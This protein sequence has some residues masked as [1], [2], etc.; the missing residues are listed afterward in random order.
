M[1]NRQLNA[2]IL[3]G[4][5]FWILIALSCNH[6]LRYGLDLNSWLSRRPSGS[7][8]AMLFMAALGWVLLSEFMALDCFR[9]G[10]QLPEMASKTST[11]ILLEMTFVLSGAFTLRLYYSRLVL[12]YFALTFWGGVVVVRLIALAILRKKHRAGNTRKVVLVGNGGVARALARRIQRHPELLYEVVGFLY[13]F[14]TTQVNTAQ[15]SKASPRSLSSLEVLKLITELRVNDLFILDSQPH[16]LEL[17]NF[18]VRCQERGIHVNF[19][20]QP[21]ELYASRP[22][23]IE[24]DGV[25]LVSLEQ[26]TGF[27]GR[28]FIKRWMDLVLGSLLLV[29]AAMILALVGIPLCA[30]ERRFLRRELRCGQGGKPFLLY[31]L[32]VD[33]EEADGSPF[34]EFLRRS[35]ITELPQLWNVFRGEMSLVGPRPESVDRVRDYSEWQRQRLKVTPGMTGLAQVNGLRE[36]HPSE[37]KTYYDLRYIMEWTPVL[38]LVLL[39]Q[40]VWTLAARFLARRQEG[41]EPIEEALLA[42]HREPTQAVTSSASE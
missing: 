25:P 20:P 42:V 38:D 30:K 8:L 39:L 12:G 6:L 35:S 40:T 7:F 19:L 14:G 34:H 33:R 13:P 5:L 24:I 26:P 1:S 17:Q 28:A 10:W 23:L 21:Y 36:Q 11:A 31:R 2:V 16:M 27:R 29:P 9:G 15:Q 3:A 32:D 22:K 37:R 18:V 41:K 4:D